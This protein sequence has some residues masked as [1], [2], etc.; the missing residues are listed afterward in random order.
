MNITNETYI[1]DTYGIQIFDINTMTFTGRDV[2]ANLGPA[3]VVKNV[4]IPVNISFS[5]DVDQ[6]GLAMYVEI[7]DSMENKHETYRL[8]VVVYRQENLFQIDTTNGTGVNITSAIMSVSGNTNGRPTFA[9]GFRALVE[10][11]GS[12]M[13]NSGE[14]VYIL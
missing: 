6:E 3:E 2:G 8:S 12:E 9:M 5:D 4:T 11:E 14:T 1:Y 7:R 13:V 10:N